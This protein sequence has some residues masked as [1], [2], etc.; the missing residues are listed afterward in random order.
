LLQAALFGPIV[1]PAIL[2]GLAYLQFFNTLGIQGTV[3][4][5]LL[6]HL[7]L[8]VP[9]A[10][11]AVGAALARAD[12]ALEDAARSLGAGPARTFVHVTLAQMRPGIAVGLVLAFIVSFNDLPVAV[13]ISGPDT[14]TLPIRMFTYVQYSNDPT[15]AAISTLLVAGLLVF[16]LIGEWRFQISRYIAQLD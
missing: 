2:I 7:T 11:R 8:T 3:F 14:T 13:F 15:I 4:A 6:A 1:F 16:V 9:Y 12:T 5:F 10:T